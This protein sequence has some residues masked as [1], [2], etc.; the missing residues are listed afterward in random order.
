MP[1]KTT[2]FPANQKCW[3]FSSRIIPLKEFICCHFRQSYGSGAGRNGVGGTCGAATAHFILTAAGGPSGT[4]SLLALLMT[5]PRQLTTVSFWFLDSRIF[6]PEQLGILDGRHLYS[7]LRF[8]VEAQRSRVQ[9]SKGVQDSCPDSGGRL[10]GD[11]GHC[12]S[13]LHNEILNPRTEPWLQLCASQM[14]HSVFQTPG[15][16]TVKEF[17]K[18]ECSEDVLVVENAVNADGTQSDERRCFFEKYDFT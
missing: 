17:A 1:P 16:K 13:H 9:K 18:E 4:I 15:G 12:S 7:W 10:Y 3:G 11:P 5:D 2:T 8:L 14:A 6:K